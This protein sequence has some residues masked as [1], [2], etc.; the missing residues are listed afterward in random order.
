MKR[1]IHPGFFNC[2]QHIFFLC[3]AAS[4]TFSKNSE[5]RT[6]SCFYLE[7]NLQL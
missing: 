3:E 2:I 6:S 4:G 5:W 7:K 1:F